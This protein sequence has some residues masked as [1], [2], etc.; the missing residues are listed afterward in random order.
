MPYFTPDDL[1]IEPSE[2][3]NSCSKR[4]IKELIEFLVEDG[5]LPKSV[6]IQSET[7]KSHSRLQS[8]FSEKLDMLAKKY[9]SISKEDEEILETIFKKYL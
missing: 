7:S 1:D 5:H 3:L 4:E 6:L 2:Y 8:E 9:H